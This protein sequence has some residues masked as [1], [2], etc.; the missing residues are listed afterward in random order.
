VNEQV[1]N[2]HWQIGW[3]WQSA[4]LWMLWQV[5]KHFWRE[6]SQKQRG[7]LMQLTLSKWAFGHVTMQGGLSVTS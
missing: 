7:S 2:F 1:P 6:L 4:A 3:P 5:S